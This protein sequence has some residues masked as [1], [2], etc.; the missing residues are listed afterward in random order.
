LE[1]RPTWISWLP[2][3]LAQFLRPRTG[4]ADNTTVLRVNLRQEGAV[5]QVSSVFSLGGSLMY[6]RKV[7]V[8]DLTSV[9]CTH[10]KE[11]AYEPD[12]P[13]SRAIQPERRQ[14]HSRKC[15]FMGMF[16]SWAAGEWADCR[17]RLQARQTSFSGKFSET[18]P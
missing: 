2:L 17:G 4:A 1:S 8:H 7:L 5:Y 11:Q 9:Y 12:A 15:P 10:N 13:T 18:T 14:E 6:V 3:R 16:V